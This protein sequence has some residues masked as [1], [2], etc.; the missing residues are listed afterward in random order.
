MTEYE[1]IPDFLISRE[2][3][4]GEEKIAELNTKVP[5][6]GDR[7]DFQDDSTGR[8]YPKH[9]GI[10]FNTFSPLR[11]E[12][13]SNPVYDR[14]N[15]YA[16]TYTVIHERRHL[17]NHKYLRQ[18]Q[19]FSR[20]LIF[21]LKMHNEISANIAMILEIRRQFRTTKN[22]PAVPKGKFRQYMSWLSKNRP[23]LARDIPTEKEAKLIMESIMNSVSF[24]WYAENYVPF[25]GKKRMQFPN[26][27]K[28][29]YNFDEI[30]KNLYDFETEAGRPFNF[31]SLLNPKNRDAFFRTFGEFTMT[32]FNQRPTFSPRHLVSKA[33]AEKEF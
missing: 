29:K 5:S 22:L 3:K 28:M 17:R 16:K 18:L 2:H 33:A 4:R 8:F 26:K 1:T 9:K 10:I 25:T 14:W 27:D 11:K 6:D 31:L 12:D 13:E 24:S 7:L 23:D 32:Y 15:N 30:V 21:T 20:D 19:K